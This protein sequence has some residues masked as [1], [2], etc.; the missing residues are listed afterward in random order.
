MY[1][2]VIRQIVIDCIDE[3]FAPLEEFANSV[4]EEANKGVKELKG[5]LD[6]DSIN[7][8]E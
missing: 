8:Q 5:L 6:S 4:L 2:D 7:D 3:I 1:Y